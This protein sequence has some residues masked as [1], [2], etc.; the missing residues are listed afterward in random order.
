MA[1]DLLGSAGKGTALS[2]GFARELPRGP[3]QAHSTRGDP[4]SPQAAFLLKSWNLSES[5]RSTHEFQL[6][7]PREDRP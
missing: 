5:G 6:R 7:T 1:A 3:L 4:A 2:P